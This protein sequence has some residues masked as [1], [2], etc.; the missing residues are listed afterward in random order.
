[1]LQFCYVIRNYLDERGRGEGGE[2]G[3]GREEVRRKER[4]KEEKSGG[5][6]RQ[7]HAT[8]ATNK[9]HPDEKH[10]AQTKTRTVCLSIESQERRAMQHSRIPTPPPPPP[11]VYH[12]LP[13][14]RLPGPPTPICHAH[15]SAEAEE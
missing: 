4:R 10:G 1:M 15:S 11:P 9:S 5:G 12:C 7:A 6:R 3:G 8:Q 2:G 13:I 14:H